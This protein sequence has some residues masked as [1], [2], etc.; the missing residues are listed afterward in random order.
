[1]VEDVG[2]TAVGPLRDTGVSDARMALGVSWVIVSVVA[3]QGI[4]SMISQITDELSL[5]ARI[6]GIVGTVVGSILFLKVQAHITRQRPTALWMVWAAVLAVTIAFVVGAWLSAALALGL[7]GIVLSGRM[8]AIVTPLYSLLLLAYMIIQDVRPLNAAFFLIVILAVGL[9]LY[10]LTRLTMA[11]AE[12]MVAREAVARL[13]VDEERHRIERDLHDILGRS[14]VAISLR[15]QTAMRLLPA[16]PEAS[17]D[18]LESVAKL[19][20]AGQGELRSLT[21]GESVIGFDDEVRTARELFERLGVPFLAD[22]D[23]TNELD[24]E[25]DRM[26]ARI[27]REGV[28]NALKHS[29]PTTV[30][31]SRRSETN[32]IVLVLINDGAPEPSEGNSGTG[33]SDLASRVEELGGTLEAAHLVR[34]RFRVLARLPRSAAAPPTTTAAHAHARDSR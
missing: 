32:S 16:S 12:L 30:E 3:F 1:M 18:Q 22:L 6:F 27:V 4:V 28:T 17:R 26:A 15:V 19:V 10:T 31:L 5:F 33:L 29:R 20:S 7:F 21:R 2:P 13:R 14:L 24:D 9:L 11:V 23:D 8:T 25:C 34:G